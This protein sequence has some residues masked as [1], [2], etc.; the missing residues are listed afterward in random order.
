MK[1]LGYVVDSKGLRVD[2]DKVNAMI[3]LPIP[4]TVKKVR[5]LIGTFNW[6]KRFFLGFA[7]T[8]APITELLKKRKKFV[9]T[10]NCNR[11][12]NQ[13]KELLVTAP[14]LSCTNYDFP[15]VIQTDAFGYVIGAVLTQPHPEGDKVISCLSRSLTRQERNYSTTERECLVYGQQKNN[16]T[17]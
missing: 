4:S 5:R 2:T 16:D 17:L 12:F 11:A 10:K 13:I 9:W 6:Y 1:Y 3:N 14:V 15:F 8:I 7:T